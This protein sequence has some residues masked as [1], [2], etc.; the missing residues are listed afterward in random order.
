MNMIIEADA[1][2]DR[3]DWARAAHCYAKALEDEPQ[4]TA[5]LVQFG[6]ASK[7]LGDFEKAR[8]AYLKFLD[9]HSDDWDVYLQL[10][11]LFNKMN[12]PKTA[13][14][15]YEQAERL[16]PG[17][18]DVLYHANTTRMRISRREIEEM[19]QSALEMVTAGRW[20]EARDLLRELV[21]S[22]ETD[23]IAIFANVTKEAGD[24]SEALKLYEAYRS[25]AK[26]V[27]PNSLVDVEIQVGHLYKAMHDFSAALRQYIRARTMEFEL[28]DHVAPESICEREIRACMREIYTCFWIED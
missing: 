23:L 4:R 8:L 10:G 12:D 26:A 17:N 1:A 18:N 24:F 22:G 20:H 5:L 28:R 14:E 2:R 16:A 25:Y 9:S 15:W 3:S 11:H 6:H 13:L 7:E 27:E 19:R 21:G